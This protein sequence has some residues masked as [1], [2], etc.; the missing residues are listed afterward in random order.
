MTGDRGDWYTQIAVA[1]IAGGGL[2]YLLDWLRD[3]K[4]KRDETPSEVD[5]SLLTVS[6]ARDELEADNARLRA[7]RAEDHARHAGERA[8]WQRREAALRSEIEH[9]E[10]RLRALLDEVT[11]LKRRNGL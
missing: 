8:E 11:D 7:E 4:R 1:L 9:L 10:A 5:A 3:R 6:K 2:K